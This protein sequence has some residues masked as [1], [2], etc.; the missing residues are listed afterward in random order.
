MK[1]ISANMRAVVLIALVLFAESTRQPGFAQEKKTFV[2]Y[3]MKVAQARVEEAV[4]KGED[5]RKVTGQADR[6]GTT[7]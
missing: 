4:R 7:G 3:S 5:F 6:E 1:W 2:A